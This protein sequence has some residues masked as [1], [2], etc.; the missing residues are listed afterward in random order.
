ME[1]KTALIGNGRKWH[2]AGQKFTYCGAKPV[3]ISDKKIPIS[4]IVELCGHCRKVIAKKVIE[5]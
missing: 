2:I 5:D 1:V 3:W 4:E